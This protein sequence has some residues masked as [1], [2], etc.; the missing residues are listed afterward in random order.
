MLTALADSG[1]VDCREILQ[2]DGSNVTKTLNWLRSVDQLPECVQMTVPR[3]TAKDPLLASLKKYSQKG[4]TCPSIKVN[5]AYDYISADFCRM[6]RDKLRDLT[7]KT[8]ESVR[9]YLKMFETLLNKPMKR[10]QLINQS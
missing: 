5:L 3:L 9:P 1:A 4:N 8:G 6:Q 2:C 10:F 7:Q